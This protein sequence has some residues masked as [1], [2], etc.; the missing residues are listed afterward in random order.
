MLNHE[1]FHSFPV[2]ENEK[3]ILKPLEQYHSKDLY[4][5]NHPEI[6]SY[7]LSQ[8]DALEDMQNW[9][10]AAI[11]LRKKN[12]ALPFIVEMKGMNKVVGTTRLYEIDAK[13][14]SCEIGSTWY[15]KDF[16]RS[17][18]NSNCKYL[19]LEYCFEKLNFVRVQFKT[20][21]RN[22][23]SQKAIERLG[24]TKEG[25]LRNEKILANGYIRNTVLY[26]ITTEEWG[27]IKND[28]K[29]RDARFQ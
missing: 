20:D 26:S 29:I 5:I 10:E 25:I 11:E 13:N 3:I 14:R 12:L 4:D 28:F 27:R 9:V 7:M 6:W 23:R 8:V 2:L 22:I 1:M 19:L 16:Q 24:A 18:V 21:E 17:F 15:G